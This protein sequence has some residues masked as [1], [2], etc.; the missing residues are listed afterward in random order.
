MF[1]F[2]VGGIPIAVTNADE[3]QALEVFESEEFKRDLVILTSDG[4]PLW[5]GKA[6]IAVRTAF[7]HE[8][9][10]FEA[11]DLDVDDFDV[12]ADEDSVFVT[13]LVPVDHDYE[14]TSAATQW[15]Q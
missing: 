2:E 7:R 1:T 6:P 14:E 3:V 8:V 11:T 9:F 10:L 5:D 12:G 15:L 13:F 4:T